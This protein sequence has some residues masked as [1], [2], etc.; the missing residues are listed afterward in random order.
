MSERAG[1]LAVAAGVL[2]L[3]VA[4]ATAAWLLPEAAGYARISVRLFPGL[5]AAGLFV[6]GVLLLREAIMPAGFRSLPDEPRWRLDWRAFAWVSAGVIAHMLLIAGIGFVAASTLLY[7]A[8]ARGFGS[9]RPARDAGV[10]LVVA[11]A[12]FVLFT[13]ALTLSLPWGAWMPGPP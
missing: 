9:A 4:F 2:A 8:T 5:I 3:G 1:Q 12:V 7:L 6:A 10:G 13:Q 11:A